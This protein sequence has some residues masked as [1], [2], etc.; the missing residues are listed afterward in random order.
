MC[1]RVRVRAYVRAYVCVCARARE[2]EQRETERR[3]SERKERDLKE[4]L[5]E[6]DSVIE[7]ISH[8]LYQVRTPTLFGGKW[9]RQ[10]SNYKV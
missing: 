1:V 10:H 5:K 3:E 9:R 6:K 8:Q 2:R 7:K 4:A